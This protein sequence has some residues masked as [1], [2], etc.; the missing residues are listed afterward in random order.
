MTWREI[1]PE[2]LNALREPLIVDV[3]SPC[4]HVKENIPHSINVPLLSD[5]ERAIVGTIYARQGEVVARREALRII[6]P[7]IPSIVDAILALRGQGQALVIHCWRGGLRSEAVASFLSV[8]GIDCFRLT[9]GYKAWRKV[10][11]KEFADDRY[12]FMPVTLHGLTG[13]GK[14]EVLAE[15]AK[16][17]SKILDLEK[18]A[19]HRGSVFGSLGLGMQ[20]TQKNFDAMLWRSLQAFG[21]EAVFLEAESR[22]IGK[23]ALPDFMLKRIAEGR[24]LLVTGT[25]RRRCARILQEYAGHFDEGTVN[26]AFE[27]LALIKE[28]LGTKRTQA[29][30]E[31]VLGGQVEEAVEALLQEYYDPLYMH[32]IK[33]YE[34]YELIVSGDD[35][36]AA[37]AAI[38]EWIAAKT[39]RQ[40]IARLS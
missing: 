24:R 33:K 11:L 5:D 8:V 6:S 1:T 18:L 16:L 4:E 23:I 40:A 7:K 14:T 22:K 25:M 2:Q 3:R 38:A 28:R 35:P 19:N 30:K 29:I 36:V 9:G 32:Q 12:A 13:V 15:L 17:G 21:N 31:Q 34:P 20:P 10:I 27:S 39:V 26:Q 37:A